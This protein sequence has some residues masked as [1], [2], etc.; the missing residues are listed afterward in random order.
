MKAKEDIIIVPTEYYDSIIFK[1]KNPKK[2]YANDFINEL[3]DM[4]LHFHCN[5][6]NKIKEEE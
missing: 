6:E 2:V 5:T 3:I 1:E 4:A